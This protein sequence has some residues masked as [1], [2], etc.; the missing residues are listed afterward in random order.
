VLRA[1]VLS[2]F[3][4][5]DEATV[6]GVLKDLVDTGMLFRSGREDTTSFRAAR[7]EDYTASRRGEDGESLLNFVWVAVS[8]YGPVS[9]EELLRHVPTSDEELSSAL[10]RLIEQQRVEAVEQ[11]PPRPPLYESGRCVIP[12]GTTSGWEASVWDHFQA[13]V[14]AIGT[15]LASGRQTARLGDAVGGSTYTFDIWPGHPHR[16]EVLS[17]LTHVRKHGVMLREKVEGHNATVAAPQPEM[18]RVIAYV[19][20]TVLGSA[21]GPSDAEPPGEAAS[22]EAVAAQS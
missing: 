12:L 2:R 20:Q 13:M 5:D 21:A 10:D 19:G 11:P 15:K 6:R 22:E 4:H 1:D 17:F 9:K 18:E 8:R 3:R 16:D 7:A 14:T